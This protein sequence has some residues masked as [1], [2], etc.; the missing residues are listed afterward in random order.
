MKQ[1]RVSAKKRSANRAS[2]SLTK[3]SITRAEKLIFSGDTEK[4]QQA[5]TRAVSVLDKTVGKGVIHR[6]NAARHKSR[7]MKKLNAA[8]APK[9]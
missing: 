9:A 7:L 1:M 5:V 3:S 2:R 8:K 6:N 4:A